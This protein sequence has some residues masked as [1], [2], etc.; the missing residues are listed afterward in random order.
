MVKVD[1]ID[2]LGLDEVV[3]KVCGEMVKEVI[4]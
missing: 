4:G 1:L 3:G 2:I